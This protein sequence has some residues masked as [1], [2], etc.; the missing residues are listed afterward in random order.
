MA[1]S[2]DAKH[3]IARST[4][5]LLIVGAMVTIIVLLINKSYPTTDGPREP[6]AKEPP[7]LINGVPVNPLTK[8]MCSPLTPEYTG[9]VPCTKQ[10]TCARCT[11]FTDPQSAYSCATVYSGNGALNAD[12]T[13]KE[14]KKITFNVP[15]TI[16]ACS[17]HGEKQADG[18][19]KCEPNFTGLACDTYTLEIQKP[20]SFCLP[21]Y[22]MQCDSPT[23]MSVYTNYNT[24]SGGQYTC[25]CKPEYVGQFVQA[26]N[27]GL[28]DTPLICNAAAPQLN[29]TQTA[30]L[31]YAVQSGTALDGSPMFTPQ[32]VYTNRVAS[33]DIYNPEPCV[34]KTVTTLNT[35]PVPYKEVNVALDADPTCKPYLESNLCV[36][37]GQAGTEVR[38]RGSNRPG[39]PLKTRASPPFYPPVPPSLRRCP[40]GF[41]GDNTPST[42]CKDST[43]KVLQFK[44]LT[45][46][47]CRN[48]AE[49]TAATPRTY[50]TAWFSSVFD[51]D[52]EWSGNFTCLHDLRNAKA[53]VGDTGTEVDVSTMPWTTLNGDTA[54]SEVK[55]MASYNESKWA[56]RGEYNATTQSYPLSGNCIG[57]SCA[58]VQGSRVRTWDGDRDG[59]LVNDNGSPWFALPQTPGTL[60]QPSFGGQCDCSGKA[61]RNAALQ[62]TTCVSNK[63]KYLVGDPLAYLN[64]TPCT[65]AADCTQVP[66]PMVALRDNPEG[67]ADAWWSCGADPCW[68][69]QTPLSTLDTSDPKFPVCTCIAGSGG[70]NT[71]P[72]TSY[73]SY[74][75]KGAM[76]QC[77]PDPCNPY[78]FL[79]KSKIMCS[80]DTGCAGKCF[81]NRC[82]YPVSADAQTCTTDAQCNAL[83]YAAN[84]GR[85][86]AVTL[87]DG[88]QKKV[89]AYEDVDRAAAGTYC[90]ADA[91][92]SY[93][94]CTTTGSDANGLPIE[95]TC[96]GG[97]ACA[98]GAVQVTQ[99]ENPVGFTCKPR[100]EYTPCQNGAVCSIDANGQQTCA[101]PKCYT[102]DKCQYSSNDSRLGE[103]CNYLFVAGATWK[104][105]F[106]PTTETGR[107]CEG[108]CQWINKPN[109]I[110]EGVCA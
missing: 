33:F 21:A 76:P 2:E 86:V 52:K 80:S 44:P 67:G 60:P 50:G 10:G 102:G 82:H 48:P 7:R 26:T 14:P 32:P 61:F 68:S 100:C 54:L 8:L 53:R 39:D 36:A 83:S 84:S 25:A 91:D 15:P 75:P 71:T 43:G 29:A 41:T 99:D 40:D 58:G 85:C 94:R 72:I 90:S 109:N 87:A 24:G 95:R 4:V 18:S 9:L 35:K 97:C 63:C 11:E 79:N 78:G 27:G 16:A 106:Y 49:L 66:T 20:G 19:C 59:P 73:I 107:C 31:Q 92:C 28:C 70:S 103:P 65:T 56:A 47:Y 1:L 69:P 110:S 51:A 6:I 45:K 81:S 34:S 5:S 3:L 42:P 98:K 108:T 88:T 77:I 12:G 93:G 55:C 89:C 13:L 57:P 74:R 101:C 105:P 37:V 22:A 96:T 104:P 17:G 30:P 64:D 38:V 62:G 46:S 23:S